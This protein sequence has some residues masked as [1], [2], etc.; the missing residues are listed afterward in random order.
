MQKKKVNAITRN[1]EQE[2]PQTRTRDCEISSHEHNP[3]GTKIFRNLRS[4]GD[5]DMT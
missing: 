3:C 1:S 5:S 4:R 2:E